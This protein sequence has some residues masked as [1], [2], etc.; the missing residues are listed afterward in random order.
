MKCADH[1]NTVQIIGVISTFLVE[2]SNND[3]YGRKN[4]SSFQCEFL[5]CNALVNEYITLKI[6]IEKQIDFL[7][8]LQH[9]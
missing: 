8:N 4:I 7:E 9:S 6:L 2:I 5:H 1:L 3:F